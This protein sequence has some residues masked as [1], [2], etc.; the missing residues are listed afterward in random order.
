MFWFLYKVR[1]QSSSIASRAHTIESNYAT[2]LTNTDSIRCPDLL[3][4]AECVCERVL[5]VKLYESFIWFPN[6][7]DE[8]SDKQKSEIS[9]IVLLNIE[10]TQRVRATGSITKAFEWTENVTT[11]VSLGEKKTE[12]IALMIFGSH[13]HRSVEQWTFT[14]EPTGKWVGWIIFSYDGI[15]M[16]IP[17]CNEHGFGILNEF[18]TKS[19]SSSNNRWIETEIE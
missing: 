4:T 18:L 14:I 1:I 19:I 12:S 5:P 15:K 16:Q 9:Y 2:L 7:S 13:A 6:R 17:L 11:R 3:Y 10:H 8:A